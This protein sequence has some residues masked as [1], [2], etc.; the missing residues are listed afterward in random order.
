MKGS[1]MRD[2]KLSVVQQAWAYRFDKL[3]PTLFGHLFA[4]P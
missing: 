1:Q 2:V 3:L 4:N